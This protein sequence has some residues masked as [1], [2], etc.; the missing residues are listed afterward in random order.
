M[1]LCAAEDHQFWQDSINLLD[2]ARFHHQLM[3]SSKHITDL[4]LLAL[5]V[6]HHAALVTFDSRIDPSPVPGATTDNIIL[7]KG[8]L[9]QRSDAEAGPKK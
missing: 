2:P 1:E 9:P 7:L 8:S 5:A 6:R 3:V 4:A